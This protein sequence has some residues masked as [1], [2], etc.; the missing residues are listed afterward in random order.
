MAIIPKL[1][2]D[3]MQFPSESQCYSSQKKK[4]H[5]KIHVESSKTLNSKSNA[6]QK[7]QCWRYSILGSKLYYRTTVTKPAWY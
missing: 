3:L 4:N 7:E 6:E 1:S 2:T 5:P